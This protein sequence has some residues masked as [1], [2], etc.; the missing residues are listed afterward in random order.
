MQL[1]LRK[2]EIHRQC[3]N[4]EGVACFKAIIDE[5]CPT[6]ECQWNRVQMSVK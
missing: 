1:Y 4:A 6:V 2:Q 3:T 5:L